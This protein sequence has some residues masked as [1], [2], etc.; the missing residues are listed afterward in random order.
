M[1]FVYGD[2][3]WMHLECGI[4]AIPRSGLVQYILCKLPATRL[5]PIL[6]LI[7]ALSVILPDA[8]K[9]DVQSYLRMICKLQQF[10]LADLSKTMLFYNGIEDFNRALGHTYNA[11]NL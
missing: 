3:Y 5:V 8:A 4:K 7:P 6:P 1:L 9:S 2:L 11:E 10:D